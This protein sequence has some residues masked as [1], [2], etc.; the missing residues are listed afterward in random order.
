MVSMSVK[1]Q[2][3]AGIWKRRTLDGLDMD[4]LYFETYIKKYDTK[5][6]FIS[7]LIE[8]NGDMILRNK[9]L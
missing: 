6:S 2:K 8:Y 4:K 9:D 7:F 5:Q 3:Y 1:R